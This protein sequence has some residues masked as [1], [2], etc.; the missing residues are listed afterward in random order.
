MPDR[1]LL[2]VVLVAIALFGA[3]FIVWAML[4]L[5]RQL[6]RGERSLLRHPFRMVRAVAFIAM[7]PALWWI[8]DPLS[9]EEKISASLAVAVTCA[10][11]ATAGLFEVAPRRIRH[12]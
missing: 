5:L 4:R 7:G 11:L 1:I 8:L 2:P 12:R 6:E 10:M 3:V 9:A